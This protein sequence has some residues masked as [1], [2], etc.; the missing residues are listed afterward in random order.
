M[1]SGIRNV[2]GVDPTRK[3]SPIAEEMHQDSDTVRLEVPGGAVCSFN[4]EARAAGAVGGIGTSPLQCRAGISG[5]A[6]PAD[7][8]TPSATLSRRA[9]RLRCDETCVSSVAYALSCVPAMSHRDTS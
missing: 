3:T 7:P 6:G 1:Q 8:K 4:D 2:G 5:E 9:P